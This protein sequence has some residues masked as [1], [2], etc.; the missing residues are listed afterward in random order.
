[1]LT[2]G[3]S[4]YG[5]KATNL[6]LNFAA[7]DAQDVANALAN[8]Q[9]GGLYAEVNPI[10]LHDGE[11]SKNAITDALGDVARNM[12]KGT[13]QDL[14]VVMFSGHGVMIEKQFYLVPYGVDSSPIG[15]QH[16]ANETI[17]ADDF[18]NRLEKLA[19]HGRVLVLLDAC[20]SAGM[21]GG[22]PAADLLRSVVNGSGVTVLTSSSADKVS[23]E[24]EKWARHG[25]FTKALLDALFDPYRVDTNRDGMISMSELTAYMDTHLTELTDGD[26]KLGLDQRFQ[27]DIFVD[28]L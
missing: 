27:G 13:G 7:R 4:D 23:R 15:M 5:D 17:R 21:I 18:R 10:F 26:Q 9:E 16:L 22:F 14:A 1:M 3:I 25:A 12:A 20:R 8:T 24:D 6:K 11:A 28:H 19:E 2:I